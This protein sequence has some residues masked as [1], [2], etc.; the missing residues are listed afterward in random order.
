MSTGHQQCR[1]KEER[2]QSK[3]NIKRERRRF[4]RVQHV[5]RHSCAT[6]RK[7]IEIIYIFSSR[8]DTTTVCVSV[9]GM[10]FYPLVFGQYITHIH[11]HTYTGWRKNLITKIV[12]FC[13]SNTFG[14]AENNYTGGIII[15]RGTLKIQGQ[16]AFICRS[17]L[18]T[19]H[20]YFLTSRKRVNEMG[21][22]KRN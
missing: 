10:P 1:G 8:T 6:K 20:E 2:I 16:S 3:R 15:I 4:V 13:L 9:I 12:D 18:S 11:T 19:I 21:R 17:K 14:V 22:G 5:Q 7:P